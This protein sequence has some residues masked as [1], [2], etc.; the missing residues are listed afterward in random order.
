MS[1]TTS[2]YISKLAIISFTDC[3]V[4]HQCIFLY[5][6]KNHLKRYQ[7]CPQGISRGLLGCSWVSTRKEK[8]DYMDSSAIKG[9]VAY[10]CTIQ[11]KTFR[12]ISSY[13]G[14][15]LMLKYIYHTI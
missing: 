11:I 6:K 9:T 3:E 13:T 7:S 5:T 10:F 4:N 1:N 2:N 15:G 14:G 8:F 12:Q